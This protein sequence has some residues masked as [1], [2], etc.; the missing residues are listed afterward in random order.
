MAARI[1]GWF[2]QT[3]TC[4]CWPQMP[5]AHGP[6]GKDKLTPAERRA[7]KGVP[8][9]FN[10]QTAGAI[11]EAHAIGGRALSYVS[12][13][14]TYV[15]TE[16]FENGTARVPWD[17]KR[18]QILLM[19]R[20][21]R[22]VNTTMDATWRMWRYFVCNNTRE[23]VDMALAMVHRQMKRGADGLFIDNSGYRRPCYGHGVPV[24]Y[25]QK[26]RS[27]C[28]AIPTW[29][30]G[31]PEGKSP[32]DLHRLGVQPRFSVA[33]P[34]IRGLPVHRHIYPGKS[35]HYAYTRLLEKVRKVVRSYGSDKIM[36]INGET[37]A[38][39]ADATMI[40]SYL[41]SWA[42]KGLSGPLCDFRAQAERWAPY[43]RS[44]RKVLALSYFGNTDRA[45]S[46]DV[47]HAW[48]AAMLSGFMW[49][50]YQTCGGKLG[51]LL[52]RLDL[53]RRL[54]GLERIGPV[55]YSFFEKGLVAVNSASRRRAVEIPIPAVARRPAL[56][57]VFDR[58]KVTQHGG[59]FRIAIP[60]H[61]GRTLIESLPR[62]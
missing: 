33:D 49:S 26:Y 39:S 11:G 31:S 44:G 5:D 56:V 62:I 27:V 61:G 3:T 24:G 20:E 21:G 57:N 22:F 25:A 18:P 34:G 58:H 6:F 46:E 19:D 37:W 7:M 48:S 50:D 14:D 15:H 13:L 47:L 4:T 16:G 2:R 60:A 59:A 54:T 28:A 52:R 32:E 10:V 53:G 40:E 30:K 35:H 38:D 41:Y 8:L 17:P 23:Y 42:W 55:D 43:L 29:P 12:F 9:F 45:V 1:P 36:L 51:R